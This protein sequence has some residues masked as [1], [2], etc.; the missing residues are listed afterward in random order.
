MS[1]DLV[2]RCIAARNSGASFPTIWRTVLQPDPLVG[3]LP[4]QTHSDGRV[5]MTVQLNTGERLIYDSQSNDYGLWPFPLPPGS[6][7]GK[8]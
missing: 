3:G 4:K 8:S 7:H 5:Q 6:D 2:R 1:A